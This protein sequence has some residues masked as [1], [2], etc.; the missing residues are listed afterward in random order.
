[1]NN[2]NK[3]KRITLSEK[4]AVIL[5]DLYFAKTSFMHAGNEKATETMSL[6]QELTETEVRKVLPVFDF[7]RSAYT[8]NEEAIKR[9]AGDN[10]LTSE[11][12][13]TSAKLSR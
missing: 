10:F 7:F 13:P 3:T 5:R 9:Q 11:I 2:E 6:R 4:E 12:L 1:M 8:E